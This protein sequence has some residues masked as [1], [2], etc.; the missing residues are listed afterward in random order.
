MTW[1]G[2]KKTVLDL[3]GKTVTLSLIDIPV[4]IPKEGI[5]R[6]PGAGS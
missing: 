5:L 6:K 1:V 4:Q 3:M 2:K